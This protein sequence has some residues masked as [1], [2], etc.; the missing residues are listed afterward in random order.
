MNLN[1]V[2]KAAAKYLASQGVSRKN[3]TQADLRNAAKIQL[4]KAGKP[5]NS[6]LIEKTALEIHALLLDK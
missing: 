1:Q 6:Q 4:F 5:Q 2:A 3:A